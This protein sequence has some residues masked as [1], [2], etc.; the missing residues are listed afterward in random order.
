MFAHWRHLSN[1]GVIIFKYDKDGAQARVE[2]VVLVLVSVLVLVLE[3][4]NL[5][6]LRALATELLPAT[7]TNG[8]A[9]KPLPMFNLNRLSIQKSD[10]AG[11]VAPPRL[12]VGN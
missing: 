12:K 7:Q 2:V 1:I 3:H 9:Q 8:Q 4:N 6:G 5:L 11:A 10:R